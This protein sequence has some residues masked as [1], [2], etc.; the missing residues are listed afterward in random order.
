MSTLDIII[1]KEGFLLTQPLS[2]G[3][4]ELFINAEDTAVGKRMAEFILRTGNTPAK[5]NI[6]VAEELLFFKSFELPLKTPDLKEAILYQLDLLTPYGEEALLHAFCHTRGKD[7]YQIC[8]YALEKKKAEP[9]VAEIFAAGYTINGLFPL[10]QRYVP[11]NTPKGKW[12]LVMPDRYAK[13]FVLET[14]H[15]E[16][17]FI[18]NTLP[19][20][21]ELKDITGA[22]TLYHLDPP[23][24]G[25]FAD[26]NTLLTDKPALREFNLLPPRFRRPDYFKPAIIV[27]LA[28]NL[29]ALLAWGGSAAYSLAKQD[30]QITEQL[31]AIRPTVEEVTTLLRQEEKLVADIGRLEEIG[32]NPDIIKL[33]ETLTLKMPKHSYLDQLEWDKKKNSIDIRG[34][35]D[36]I[37]DLTEKL[38]SVGDIKLQSTSRRKNKTYFN[39]DVTLQ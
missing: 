28:L 30:Q 5:F 11:K 1:K 35:T 18:C 24:N 12:V 20:F 29:I 10:H 27:L 23:P 7:T 34:Y 9:L 4:A 16:D 15:L 14:T 17:R 8:L 38:Q 19:H 36:D 37:G 6:Y 32:Q 26:G 2:T 21:G 22:E 13:A 33:L 31:N 3:A 25:S 39:I